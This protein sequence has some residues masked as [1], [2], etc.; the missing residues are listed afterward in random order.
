MAEQVDVKINIITTEN[1]PL[2]S[3]ESATEG[4]ADAAS[5]ASDS[6]EDLGNNAQAAS[7]NIGKIK[8][9]NNF[10]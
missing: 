8:G 6:F 7:G 10:M 4:I 1:P 9:V 5:S 3:I 2:A